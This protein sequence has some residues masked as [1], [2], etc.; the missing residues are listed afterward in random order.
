[1]LSQ[2]L[3]SRMLVSSLVMRSRCAS[4]TTTV[5]T[6]SWTEFFAMRKNKKLV[7]RT[8]GGLGGVFGLSLGSYYFLFVAEFDPFQQI[9]GLDPS[10][11]YMLGAFSTGIVSAVAGS[12]G[13]NQLWRL[14]RNPSMLRAFDLKEKEFHQRI[15][16]H[17][18]KELP[19]FTTASP[20]RPPTPPDYYGEHIYSFSGYRKW[21]RRQRKFIAATAESSP[22]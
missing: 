4:T 20:T 13:A 8:V 1:M 16:R 18:P 10:M 12:L 7:E 22:K 6:I 5:S 19:L 2:I 21:I 9:W 11:P 14:M 15:L 3:H 17:R